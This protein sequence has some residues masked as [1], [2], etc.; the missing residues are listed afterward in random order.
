MRPVQS[1]TLPICELVCM[2]T[3]RP[4]LGCAIRHER[5]SMHKAL[6]QALC[7]VFIRHVLVSTS[8]TWTTLEFLDD[9]AAGKT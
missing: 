9:E 6:L 5:R 7:R 2:Y 4:L 8:R 3:Y 1:V